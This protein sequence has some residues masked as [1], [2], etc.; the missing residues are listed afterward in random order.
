M[1]P[2]NHSQAPRRR[3]ALLLL[4]LIALQACG[5]GGSS[6]SSSETSV[7]NIA[8]VTAGFGALGQAGG[9]ANGIW[10]SVTVCVPG[11]SNCQTIPNVLVDTGSVGLRLLGSALT[12]SLPGVQGSTGNVLQECVQFASFA[13]TWGPV[14]L[15]T[16]QIG[17]ANESAAQVPGQSANSGIP[18]QIISQTPAYTV[19]SSCLATAPSPGLTVDANT[20]D[21]LG[22]N[23]I[24]GVGNFSQDCGAACVSQGIDEYYVCP[25]G[26]CTVVNVPLQNQLWNPVAAFARD[27][28]GVLLELPAVS[29]AGA[30]PV[31]GSLI[32]GIGTESNNQ[33]GSAKVYELDD[34]GNF[35]QVVFNGTTYASPYNGSFLD[36]GSEGYFVSDAGSLASAGIVECPAGLSGYYCPAATV[37]LNL[38]IYGANNV[39]ST[40]QIDIANAETLFGSENAV[41][42]DLGGDSGTGPSSDYVDLG[43]PFFFGRPIFVGIEGLSSAYPNGY[44]A[45]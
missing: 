38:T 26:A 7:N 35:P 21:E 32:F 15:A 34:Y 5:G 16:V 29:A 42:N 13:Y 14:G 17:G 30:P 39:E 31:N 9:Y 3:P 43:L 25:N 1:T 28:N 24:L 33:I 2:A 4:T 40:L 22:G 19:P 18:V 11:T 36:S 44:W 27:N 45:F 10:T 12:L 8:S 6:S 37:P 41:F 20:L 23:G